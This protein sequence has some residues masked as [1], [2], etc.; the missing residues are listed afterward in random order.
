MERHLIMNLKKDSGFSL[1]EMSI[2]LIISGIFMSALFVAA[3]TLTRSKDFDTT[4]EHIQRAQEALRD[5]YGLNGRYP[6]PAN[7]AL[8]PANANYGLEDCA[9][10]PACPAADVCVTSVG[11]R[12]ADGLGGADDVLIG[13]LPINTLSENLAD[14][15]SL[16]RFKPYEGTDG[17]NMKFTYAVTREMT[18]ATKYNVA[19]PAN[20]QLGAIALTDE[21][22]RDLVTPASSAHYVIVS[23]GENRRGG[24][25]P[26]GQL[27]D[28]C[29]IINSITSAVE[30]P[31]NNVT[32]LGV[33]KELEN[34]DDNDAVFVKGLRSMVEDD[35]YFDDIVYFNTSTANTLWAV[36]TMNPLW[37]YN[38]NFGNVGVGVDNPLSKLEINGDILADTQIM[39][40][41]GFCA[42]DGSDC[43]DP[44]ALG[45]TGMA[46]CP[47]G[48]MATGIE[49]NQL[50]CDDI[51]P[52]GFT[53][54][55]PNPGEYVTSFTNKGNVTC[56]AP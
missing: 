52:P 8:A 2:V 22:G 28:D 15:G 53:I 24:Y 44:N 45:G 1:V 6:C 41:D 27:V 25:T 51:L 9:A 10:P 30:T 55:C 33:R 20:V 29:T 23:H 14:R 37:Y 32:T 4:Q 47:V 50:V 12:D 31:G 13:A 49:N 16:V 36:S 7:P 46:K 54:S 21:F 42:Q 34:C 18:D 35:N 48:Q 39:A 26:L 17:Y 40:Q 5:F 19:M 43:L 11:A 3:A 56:A 38:T